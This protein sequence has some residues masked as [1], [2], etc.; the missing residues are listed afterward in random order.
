[1]NDEL[2]YQGVRACGP[3]AVNR[4]V[5][6]LQKGESVQIAAMLATRTPPAL[7]HNDQTVMKNRQTLLEQFGGNVRML[8]AYNRQY[9]LETGEDIPGDAVVLRGLV[10]YPGDSEFILTH[11]HTLADVQKAAKKRNIEVHGDWEQTPVSQ[12]PKPQEVRLRPD[13]VDN[14]VGEYLQENPDLGRET[15]QDL[16]EMVIADKSEK[17]DESCLTPLGVDSKDKLADKLFGKKDRKI[18]IVEGL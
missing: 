17:L 4:F 7:G 5:D 13:I 10:R 15:L 18:S 12:A 14:Y 8:E 16:R 2:T 3:Q 9:K 6:L 11:K 1:M